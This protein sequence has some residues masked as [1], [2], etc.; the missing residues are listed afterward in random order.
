M[1]RIG[2]VGGGI[3]GLHLGLWLCEYGLDA[4][5]YSEK[6]S[7]QL[8][9]APMAAHPGPRAHASDAARPTASAIP[10]LGQSATAAFRVANSPVL[11]LIQERQVARLSCAAHA[12]AG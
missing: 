12:L 7:S 8:L 5:I 9:D 2:I 4:T 10:G 6:T 11:A 1:K 3:S